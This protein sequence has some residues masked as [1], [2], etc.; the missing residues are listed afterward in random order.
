MPAGSDVLGLAVV[1]PILIVIPI[2]PTHVVTPL[3]RVE[4]KASNS[5]ARESKDALEGFV[6]ILFL[7][8]AWVI[9]NLNPFP[10]LGLYLGV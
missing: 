2:R 4:I 3:V 8:V 6:K 9:L 5:L 7:V 10:G 1:T